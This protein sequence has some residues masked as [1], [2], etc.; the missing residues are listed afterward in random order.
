VILD[1]IVAAKLDSLAAEKAR[2]PPAEVKKRALRQSPAR[3]SAG[4]LRGKPFALIAEVKEAS[5]SRGVMCR[6]FDPTRMA[7]IYSRG[8]AAAISVLTEERFFQGKLEYIGKIRENLGDA[9]PPL[10]RK[11]F[12]LD[13]YQVYQSRAAGADALLLIAAILTREKLKEL[14]DLSHELGMD[15]LVETHNEPEIETTL[16]GGAEIIGINNRDLQTFKVD[17]DN[18]RRLRPLVP[19]GRLV[20]SESGIRG[21]EDIL[22]MKEWGVNAILVGEALV[23]APDIALKM[24]EFIGQD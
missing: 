7:A 6:D 1:E 16:A 3:S 11:D 23:S 13:A 10:L 15:C 19:P 5:P 21:N 2:V 22:K 9:C 4:A 17:L 8:G 18:T 14:L 12:I 20:V 24:G